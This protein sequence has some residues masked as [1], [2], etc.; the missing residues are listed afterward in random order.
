MGNPIIL[1][2]DDAE[3][4]IKP[5]KEG[6]KRRNFTII[7]NPLI[8]NPDEFK[9]SDG[10]FR[11]LV[12]LQRYDGLQTLV[13]SAKTLGEKLPNKNGKPRSE[14]TIFNFMKELEDNGYI[15]RTPRYKHNGE[16]KQMSS[17]ISLEP[18]R[19]KVDIAQQNWL[20][21]RHH[22]ISQ[23]CK[24]LQTEENA[25][26]L[27]GGL[28]LKDESRVQNTADLYECKILQTDK[29]VYKDYK[30]INGFSEN[31]S[32]SHKDK[33]NEDDIKQKKESQQHP[34]NNSLPDEP[35]DNSQTKDTGE[36]VNPK[37]EVS[38][39]DLNINQD[40]RGD[41]NGQ[42]STV[43]PAAAPS[44][45]TLITQFQNAMKNGVGQATLN[46]MLTEL[47][48]KLGVEV[49]KIS[50][51]YNYSV[52]GKGWKLKKGQIIDVL[53]LMHQKKTSGELNS[54]T[55]YWHKVL[56]GK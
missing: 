24:I 43:A 12:L 11:L 48:E 56:R 16:L 47:L 44:F 41:V 51:E 1:H 14:R 21:S 13:F 34:I 15:T 20:K 53:Y 45:L 8:D 23:E 28:E 9:L 7:D 52:A 2:E 38:P 25:N 18:F 37:S 26:K 10:A 32:S 36:D 35:P 50:G 3:Y 40:N 4:H 39:G 27:S 49:K 5:S 29:D 33:D 6:T 54:P 17:V 30:D 42:P 31:S 46:G 55:G 22:L 19:Q